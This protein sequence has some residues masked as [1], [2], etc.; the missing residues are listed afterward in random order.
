[1]KVESVAEVER[2]IR[3][4]MQTPE[5]KESFERSNREVERTLRK[6]H[7]DCQVDPKLLDI[8]AVI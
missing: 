1:M 8:P 7:E 6:L 2:T 5:W 4:L 3:I